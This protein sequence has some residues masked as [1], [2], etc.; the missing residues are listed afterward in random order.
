LYIEKVGWSLFIKFLKN[1]V[2][3][4]IKFPFFGGNTGGYLNTRGKDEK[5]AI[6]WQSTK[7]QIFEMPTGG[8]AIMRTGENLIYFAR[9]EQSIAL[10]SQLKTLKIT[11]YKIY[12]IFSNGE[13]HYLHPK[14]G[15]LPEKVQPERKAVNSTNYTNL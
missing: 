2:N 6:T 1:M 4:N 5:Y 12:R 11:N 10:A 15:F 14:D 3:L 8:S 13:I 9:K 7:D